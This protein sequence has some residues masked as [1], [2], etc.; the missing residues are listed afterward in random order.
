MVLVNINIVLRKQLIKT[1]VWS[2]ALYGSETWVIGE[3]ER[4]KIE[5]FEMWC[6]R[7][8]NKIKWTDKISN[9]RVL[10]LIGEK[11][12]I[13][14]MLG[15]RRHRWIGHLYRHSNFMV[16]IIEGRRHGNQGRGRPRS[17]YIDQVMKYSGSE[18]YDEMKR[19]TSDR[20]EWRAINQSSD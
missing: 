1:L 5:A 16:S 2:I 18:T 11:R 10:E 4:K 9:E 19:K 12:Q 3:I 14:N 6:W 13:W 8:M 7:K 20:V 17:R 15:E